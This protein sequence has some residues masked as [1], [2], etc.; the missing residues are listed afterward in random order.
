MA[1]NLLNIPLWNFDLN[2]FIIINRCVISTV[3]FQT[4]LIKIPKQVFFLLFKR[5]EW[6]YVYEY[7]TNVQIMQKKKPEKQN[8]ENGFILKFLFKR[9]L[10]LH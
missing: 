9:V 2:S 6:M 8:L 1:L 7:A 10:F 4:K 3:R 5:L